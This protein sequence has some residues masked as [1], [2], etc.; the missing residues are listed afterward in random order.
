MDAGNGSALRFSTKNTKTVSPSS[1]NCSQTADSKTG[2]IYQQAPCNAHN[3]LLVRIAVCEPSDS[4]YEV[5]IGTG[6][7]PPT[8]GVYLDRK[9][10]TQRDK[11]GNYP[12]QLSS[13]DFKM[14]TSQNGQL[15]TIGIRPYTEGVYTTQINYQMRS[16]N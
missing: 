3:I 2:L 13:K 7:R 6:N 1:T 16:I 8:T 4:G 5:F 12:L 14:P 11:D 10:L 9:V 15:C